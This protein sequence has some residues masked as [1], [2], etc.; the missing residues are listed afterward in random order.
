MYIEKGQHV[1]VVKFE[2]GQLHVI[3]VV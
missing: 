1:K 3:P 2:N